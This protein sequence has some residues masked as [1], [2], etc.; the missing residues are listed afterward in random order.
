MNWNCNGNGCDAFI[1]PCNERGVVNSEVNWTVAIH[2]PP[3]L[4]LADMPCQ[5]RKYCMRFRPFHCTAHS[6]RHYLYALIWHATVSECTMNRFITLW[7]CCRFLFIE[8]NA[9]CS[10]LTPTILVGLVRIE[11]VMLGYAF[12]GQ[13]F[14]VLGISESSIHTHLRL[15]HEHRMRGWTQRRSKF[16]IF[17]S[18]A[19]HQLVYEFISHKHNRPSRV[20]ILFDSIFTAVRIV[21]SVWR[22]HKY[23][24]RNL[25]ERHRYCSMAWASMSV[26]DGTID[27]MH[28]Q[29]V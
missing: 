25:A 24:L 15:C 3:A 10:V 11:F 9:M 20:L 7:C 1:L 28:G 23:V 12:S 14:V 4:A 17:H 29:N 26:K 2:L 19:E 8:A 6:F 21:N 13:I 16:R 22:T 27:V 18:I 5:W